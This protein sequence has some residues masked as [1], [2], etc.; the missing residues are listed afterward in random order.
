MTA[1]TIMNPES[2]LDEFS[3]PSCMIEPSDTETTADFHTIEHS[4]PS[5]EEE[6][7]ESV[8]EELFDQSM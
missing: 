2:T 4:Q 7:S 8:M 6:E 1:A 3:G 5:E